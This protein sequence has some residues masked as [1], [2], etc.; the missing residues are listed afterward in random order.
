[1]HRASE[2]TILLVPTLTA[3]VVKLNQTHLRVAYAEVACN[4]CS[5]V[6]K[7]T[8][9]SPQLM[10]CDQGQSVSSCGGGSLYTNDIHSI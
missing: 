4:S 8:H 9:C 1:M 6:D 10:V 3:V 7:L 2:C 5:S